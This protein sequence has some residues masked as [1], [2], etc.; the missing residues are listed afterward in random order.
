MVK[1]FPCRQPNSVEQRTYF[2]GQTH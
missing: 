1:Q 2:G